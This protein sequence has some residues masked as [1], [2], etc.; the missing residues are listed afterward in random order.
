MKLWQKIYLVMLCVS[1][2]FVNFGIYTVF[3]VTYQKNITEEQN[4][5][6]VSYHLMKNMVLKNMQ[7]LE[8]QRRMN[9]RTLVSL[10]ELFEEE[11]SRQKISVCLW[12]NG[13]MLYGSEENAIDKIE[14]NQTVVRIRGRSGEKEVFVLGKF[15]GL[16]ENYAFSIC[17][18]L[19]ELNS[20]W[21]VLG[22]IY[23]SISFGISLVLALV[24]SIALGVL[25]QPLGSFSEQVKMIR[26][27]N[28]HTRLLMRGEDEL[29]I[30][31]K[32][33]NEMADTIEEHVEKLERENEKKQRFMDD[34][35]HEMKSPLT[36]IYG[37]AEYMA[38]AKVSEEERVELCQII[39]EES[40]LIG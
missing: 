21:K 38:K 19:D 12:E 15:H 6:N 20:M 36:S 27:G 26:D 25:L 35:S 17:Y 16:P 23:I 7:A 8:Q 39:M 28:Y 1:I 31:G 13:K 22:N 2:L 4:R 9:E 33:I 24:L 3:Q 14:E 37:Y 40:D 30:L 29:S 11:V 5:A 10:M 32:D 18:P 34:F